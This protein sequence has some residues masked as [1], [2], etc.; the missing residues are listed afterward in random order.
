A[1]LAWINPLQNPGRLREHEEFSLYWKG[2]EEISTTLGFKMEE[3]RTE[4]LSLQRMDTIFRTRN[5]RGLLIAPLSWETT[6]INWN[7]M[8]WQ[9]YAAVRFGRSRIGPPLHIVTSAQVSNTTRAFEKMQELGYKRIGFF[10][11]AMPRRM[12]TAGYLRAQLAQPEEFRLPMAL[13][14]TTDV[15]ELRSLLKKWI[16]AN[17]P[18][19][20]MT[21]SSMLPTLLNDLGIKIPDDIGIATTSIHDTPINAGIDQRPLEIGKSAVRMLVSLMNE[22]HFGIPETRNHILVEGK[23]VN[24]SMLPDRS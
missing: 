11:D 2:A 22:H 17:R 20:I 18:D 1:I 7:E 14:N 12:F 23:W 3:F 5:I 10:G 4:D 15:I 19:A 13:Y 16:A 6:P 8:P 21:D 24:G 9:D